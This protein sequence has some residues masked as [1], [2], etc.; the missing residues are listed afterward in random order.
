MQ[1][2]VLFSSQKSLKAILWQ[3]ENCT[4]LDCYY[5]QSVLLFLNSVKQSLLSF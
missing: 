1:T 4:N 5:I 3:L 2:D